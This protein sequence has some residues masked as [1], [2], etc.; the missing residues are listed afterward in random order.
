[1]S[2]EIQLLVERN[3]RE[4]MINN[5]EVLEKVKQL[6]TLPNTEFATLEQVAEFYEVTNRQIENLIEL[7]RE[8]LISDGFKIYKATDFKTETHFGIKNVE[9]TRGKFTVKFLDDSTRDFSPRGISLFPRRAVLRVGMLLRESKIA[10]QI[11]TYLLNLEYDT[12]KQS[13]EI[14]TNI[15][16]EISEEQDLQIKAME[17]Y[18][19]GDLENFAKYS[20]MINAIRNKRVKEIEREN[21]ALKFE[22][23]A[24]ANG[25]LTLD[26]QACVNKMV[27]LIAVHVFRVHCKN[28]RTSFIKAWDKLYSHLLNKYDISIRRRIDNRSLAHSRKLTIFDVLDTVEETEYV[29]KSCIALCEMY[30][31][32]ISEVFIPK[33][34]IN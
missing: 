15:T 7:N 29:V 10:K 21:E 25:I 26:F 17:S 2:N 12:Q 28:E 22:N 9:T 27:R 31:I 14:I 16:H 32:D 6:I 8:E 11:R 24:L 34:Y 3:L 18:T 33:E 4:Q 13:P 1:M 5:V 19:N 20:M 30:K 23:N